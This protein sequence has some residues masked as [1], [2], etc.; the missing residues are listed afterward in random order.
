MDP[1][2]TVLNDGSW[3]LVVVDADVLASNHEIA[4]PPGFLGIAEFAASAIAGGV[5]GNLTYDAL[6]RV[7]IRT[8]ERLGVS[9]ARRSPDEITKSVRD[10]LVG[11]GYKVVT[12]TGVTEVRD[13]G[14]HVDGTADSIDF[15][16]RA[17]ATGRIVHV[18]VNP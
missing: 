18:S 11:N 16:A 3:L 6:K 17:D 13:R 14:W 9:P 5:A 7:A 1:A 15:T 2:A 12:L 4:T 8:F 10:F